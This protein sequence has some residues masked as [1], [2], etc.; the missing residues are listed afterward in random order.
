M[1]YAIGEMVVA[2]TEE[3]QSMMNGKTW[4]VCRLRF[5]LHKHP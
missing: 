4:S 3:Q 2:A 5:E 1:L